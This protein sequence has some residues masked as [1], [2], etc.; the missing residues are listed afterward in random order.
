ML[1][2]ILVVYPFLNPSENTEP[3]TGL[4]WQIEVL[5]DGSTRVFG[6]K[7]S[8]S[9][10]SY[11]IDILGNDMEI[12]IIAAPDEVGNLEMYYGHYRA[13]LISG[14]LILQTKASEQNIK[15]WRENSIKSDYVATGRAKKYTLSADDLTHALGEII[16]GLIF[17][18]AVNLDE[19]VIL[20]R[21]GEPDERILLTEVTHFL[22]PEK[23]LDIALYDNAKEV[24][25]YVLPNSPRKQ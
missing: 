13:G 1:T 3:L 16:T 23:G 5:P 7:I 20:A 10:L 25:Q 21:F 4:P 6:L 12:A 22:Y 24:I 14:K 19:E 18:P 2:I 15:Y 9:R 17:I 8:E 11:A